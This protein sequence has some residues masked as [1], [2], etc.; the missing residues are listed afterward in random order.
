MILRSIEL[1]LDSRNQPIM[2][3]Q[4]TREFR[5]NP[6]K[7]THTIIPAQAGIQRLSRVLR[8]CPWVSTF[9]WKI[10][11]STVSLLV[12]VVFLLTGCVAV[13]PGSQNSVLTHGKQT[14]VHKSSVT[15]HKL[16]RI[17]RRKAASAALKRKF[18]EFMLPKIEQANHEVL[19]ERKKLSDLHS[20]WRYENFLPK[21]QLLWLADLADKYGVDNADFTKVKAWSEL[22][23]RVDSLPTSLVLA[24]AINESAWG[25]SY[26]ARKGKNYFGQ[27]CS[28]PGCGIVPRKRPAGKKY[29]VR[30]FSNALNSIRSYLLNI[31][32]HRTY[33]KLRNLRQQ[34]R[35]ADESLD[36]LRLA[37]GLVNY[38][39]KGEAYVKILQSIIRSYNL[40]KY[41]VKG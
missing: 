27:W 33:Y 2:S 13:P 1:L 41:D 17:Q 34:M 9:Y 38:S 39:E 19:V 12:A 29:E 37:E 24:Q 40:Q 21:Q 6:I 4:Q 23:L 36:G 32:T 30:K 5:D 18:I 14:A 15:R 22:L 25:R 8:A 7:S 28:K 11:F 16:S 31:N 35:L 3:L 20:I 26:F 10:R